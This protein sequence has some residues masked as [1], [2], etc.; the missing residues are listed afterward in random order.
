MMDITELKVGDWVR[1]NIPPLESCG[2]DKVT[3]IHNKK[4]VTLKRMKD[5]INK[6]ISPIE[7]TEDI[8]LRNGYK[9]NISDHSTYIHETHGCYSLWK[10]DVC[11]T[12]YWRGHELDT[13]RINYVHQL[14]HILWALDIDQEIKL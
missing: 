11:W 9:P 13:L 14:Q 10:R 4:L 1:F 6:Q 8:L 2:V 7:L 3:A 12:M 5:V